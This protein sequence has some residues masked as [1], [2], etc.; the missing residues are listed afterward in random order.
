MTSLLSRKIFTYSLL[1]L[2]LIFGSSTAVFSSHEEEHSEEA[3]EEFEPTAVIMHH[4]M[5]A[6]DWHI[7]DWDGHAVSIPLP[8]ILYTHNGIVTFMSSEFH[9]DDEGHHVATIGDQSFVKSHG[10]I[11]YASDVANEH[12]AYLTYVV[13]ETSGEEV[14]S[15]QAPLDF[16]LTKNAVSILLVF[17]LILIVFLSVA[18]SY[19]NTLGVPKKGLAKFVEPLIIFIRDDV[20][21]QNIGK[22]HYKRFTPYLLTLFFFIWINNMVGLIPFFPGGANTT[23]NIAVTFVLAAFTLI[24]ML[25]N[26][27][28]HWW[29]HM[30]WMP[31]VPIPVKILLAPIELVGVISKPFALMI[32]L[33]ANMTA[34]HIVILSLISLVFIFKTVL[35]SPAAVGLTL[36]IFVIKVLVA[37][38]Q[39]YIFAL[40]TALF[41]GQALEEPH[42]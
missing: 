22:K 13:D 41:I 34:G 32:R 4:I 17:V 2:G 26:G 16:S 39:A 6:H 11:Y 28:K 23:G 18:K 3:N 19:K 15:N 35:I 8:V 1:I 10:H 24:L 30:L 38:L 20:A 5:D 25:A 42:H 9:H 7:F 29:G 37:F 40:L 31:G 27:N 12:G 14:L 21:L 33:F 36:F